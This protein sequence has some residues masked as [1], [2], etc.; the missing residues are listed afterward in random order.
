MKRQKTIGIA[1]LLLACGL[2]AP[3]MAQSGDASELLL[4]QA[5]LIFTQG[6]LNSSLRDGTVATTDEIYLWVP[7]LDVNGDVDLSATG[8]FFLIWDSGST[9]G[10]PNNVALG[11]NDDEDNEMRG[12]HF[13][14]ADGGSF[15][16]SYD[17]GSTTGFVAEASIPDGNLIRVSPDGPFSN[18]QMQDFLLATELQEGVN[19]VSGDFSDGD[20][21]GFAVAPD[22]SFYWASGSA[23]LE[24]T[25]GGAINKA[26][27]E[28]AHTEG[29]AS[30]V[31]SPR[32]IGDTLFYDSNV[33]PPGLVFPTFIN[34][35]GRAA[36]VLDD[37]GVLIGVSDTY[38]YPND[39]DTGVDILLDRWDVGLIDPVT[40][41]ITLVYPG[42]LFFQ[43]IDTTNAEMLDLD[44]FDTQEELQAF[45]AMIG[46]DSDPGMALQAFVI[47][48]G[49]PCNEAD[50]AEPFD[51]LDFSDVVA[52]LTAFGAMAPEADLALPFGSFDFSDVVAFLGAFGAGCP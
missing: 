1:A 27:N 25:T 20:L 40:F 52:F 32:N 13:D 15:L 39:A 7:A 50:L 6:Q 16:I 38:N 21:Y 4:G 23:L 2:A 19:G 45:Q 3:A 11:G 37:G 42:E 14:P 8:Q 24:T 33:S 10:S 49:G 31:G 17:D 47:E 44:V 36:E 26:S 51:Q 46:A 48:A 29:F 34:G 22:G 43:T 5:P 12:L 30:P 28:F 35:Q 9:G 41:D 18:G